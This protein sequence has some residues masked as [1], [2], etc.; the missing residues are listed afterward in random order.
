MRI[1]NINYIAHSQIL[2]KYERIA[3][4][5]LSIQNVND[6]QRFYFRLSRHVEHVPFDARSVYDRHVYADCQ[7]FQSLTHVS[8]LAKSRVMQW[9]SLNKAAWNK[10]YASCDSITR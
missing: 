3:S 1:E 10:S 2:I 4:L 7:N 9:I 5:V 8:R 6:H